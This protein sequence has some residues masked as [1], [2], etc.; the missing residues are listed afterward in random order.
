MNR[1]QIYCQTAFPDFDDNLS[2]YVA[3]LPEGWSDNSWKHDTCP[4]LALPNGIRLWIDY[5]NPDKAEYT[6][7]RKAGTV[8]RFTLNTGLDE[9]D[10]FQTDVW[11]VMREFIWANATRLSEVTRIT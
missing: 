3:E 4:H 11:S 9:P 1:S 2:A 5:A 6:D 7:E 8:R 10:I